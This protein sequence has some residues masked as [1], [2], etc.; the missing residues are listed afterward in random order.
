MNAEWENYANTEGQQKWTK[1]SNYWTISGLPM[2]WKILNIKSLNA[3]DYFQNNIKHV[4]REQDEQ[5]IK[6]TSISSR[7]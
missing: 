6:Y 1:P 2:M 5:M 3:K 4:T 7:R